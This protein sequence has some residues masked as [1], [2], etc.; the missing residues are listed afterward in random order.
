VSASRRVAVFAI[1]MGVALGVG[2]MAGVALSP[3][4]DGDE[5]YPSS[6]GHAQMDATHA[7]T[8]AGLAVTDAGLTLV[9]AKTAF[10]PG[11]PAVF[12]FRV[13]DAGGSS[14][15]DMDVGHEELMHMIVASRDMAHYQHIHPEPQSDGSWAVTLTLPEAGVYRAFAD[16][17]RDGQ[18]HTLATDVFADGELRSRPLPPPSETASGGGYTAAI[19]ERSDGPGMVDLTYRVSGPDGPVDGIPPYLGAAAHVVAL[20]E[21]DMAFIHAHADTT[22]GDAAGLRVAVHVP[23]A[24]RYRV[25]IQFIHDGA[26]RTVAHTLQVRR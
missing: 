3:L 18:G 8:A 4:R 26:V 23:S 15:Q 17:I 13:V 19:T 10:E 24:G 6:A 1:A 16:F 11:A 7:P 25:F 20:R 14:L 9:P 21:G 5:A 12:R 22:P 2:A